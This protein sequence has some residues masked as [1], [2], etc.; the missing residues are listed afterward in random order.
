MITRHYEV[1]GL[2]IEWGKSLGE[3]RVL[4][5]EVEPLAPSGV[6]PE[7]RCR[8]SAIFGLE[9]TEFIA[10]APFEDRPVL[11]VQYRLRPVKH[12]LSENLH[13]PF[14]RPLSE[15]LGHPVETG[16]Y[17]LPP[18]LSEEYLSQMV[19]YRAQWLAG[20][21][22]VRLAVY[23][24]AAGK[25]SGPCAAEI[26]VDWLDE[27]KAAGPYREQNQFFETIMSGSLT[28]DMPLRKFRLVRQQYPCHVTHHE[29]ENPDIALFDNEWRASQMALY[30][31]QLYQTPLP[32]QNVLSD[33]EIAVYTIQAL[34]KTFV[35]TKWDTVFLAP[36][37]MNS[38]ICTDVLPARGSGGRELM[39]KELRIED[40]SGSDALTGL[41]QQIEQVTGLKA[42]KR[43]RHNE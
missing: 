37:D 11:Q 29:L 13:D 27:K 21:L 18:G 1:D 12:A 9:A 42:E 24:A 34:D 7:V 6:W 40:S 28:P 20:L 38:I 10:R 26:F 32:V 22:S 19:V 17:A 3:V 33:D 15:A 4:L 41:L 5:A 31:R 8:C 30:K 2:K 14:L 23:G 36:G 16:N 25:E 43:E 39:L 35:S